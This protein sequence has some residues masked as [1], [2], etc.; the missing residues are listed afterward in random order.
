[1][2]RR[3]QTPVVTGP[4]LSDNRLQSS[5]PGHVLFHGCASRAY[6][7]GTSD[8]LPFRRWR[9]LLLLRMNMA[10]VSEKYRETSDNQKHPQVLLY[11]VYQAHIPVAADFTDSRS[12]PRLA[13]LSAFWELAIPLSRRRISIPGQVVCASRVTVLAGIRSGGGH[14]L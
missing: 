1:M 9:L 8:W 10:H 3:Q 13:P 14:M 5:F 4:N 6:S 12:Q 7:G 2:G 11:I